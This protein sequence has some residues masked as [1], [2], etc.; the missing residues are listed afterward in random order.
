M[1]SLLRDPAFFANCTQLQ[2]S[3][4]VRTVTYTRANAFHFNEMN[5]TNPLRTVTYSYVQFGHKCS[6]GTIST[7]FDPSLDR[8]ELV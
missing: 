1:T 6:R 7:V 2:L 8:K 5:C 3:Y 4:W